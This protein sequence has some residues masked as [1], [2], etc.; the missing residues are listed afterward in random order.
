MGGYNTICEVLSLGRPALIV[1]RADGTFTAGNTFEWSVP[2][3]VGVTASAEE[4]AG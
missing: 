2:I 4:M 3:E 1:P